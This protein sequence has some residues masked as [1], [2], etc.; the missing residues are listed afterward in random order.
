MTESG[1]PGRII[2]SRLLPPKQLK[3]SRDAKAKNLFSLVSD[4][5]PYGKK[6]GYRKTLRVELPWVVIKNGVVVCLTS[7]HSGKKEWILEARGTL[8]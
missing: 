8:V 2:I 4:A 6:V 7:K 3:L 5:S 1:S